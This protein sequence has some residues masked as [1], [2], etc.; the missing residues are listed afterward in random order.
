MS[1]GAGMLAGVVMQRGKLAS[2]GSIKADTFFTAASSPHR[3][4]DT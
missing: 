4:L 3:F 1:V 2:N